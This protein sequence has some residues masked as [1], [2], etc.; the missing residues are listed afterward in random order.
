MVET[1]ERFSARGAGDVG[2][3]RA[4]GYGTRSVS[5][6]GVSSE[7]ARRHFIL[8]CGVDAACVSMLSI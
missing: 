7:L 3:R 6:G 5:T 2:G 1:V 8:Y 4:Q